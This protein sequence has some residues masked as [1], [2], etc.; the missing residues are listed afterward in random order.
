MS[1]LSAYNKKMISLLSELAVS[2]GERVGLAIFAIFLLSGV[3][4]SSF[5]EGSSEDRSATTSQPSVKVGDAVFTLDLSDKELRADLADQ[6]V[7]VVDDESSGTPCIKIESSAVKNGI[8]PGK[9]VTLPLDIKRFQGTK[10]LLS[11]QVRADNI[12]SAKENTPIFRWHGVKCQFIYNSPSRGMQSWEEGRLQSAFPWRHVEAICG[13]TRD[14]KDGRLR[15]GIE[16]ALGTVWIKDLTLTVLQT[17]AARPTPKVPN[18]PASTTLRGF[19]SPAHFKEQD[20][21]DLGKLNVNL[22]RW[23]LVGSPKELANYDAWLASKLDELGEALDAAFANGIKLVI[24]LHS[25]PG[26]RLT[27]DATLRMVMEKPYQDRF[28]NIWEDIARRFKGH[29]ALYA[30]D[31][32]NEPVQNHVSPPGLEDWLGIQ[33]KA[34]KAI[35]TIDATTPI[36]IEMDRWCQPDQ[37]IWLKGPVD[38]TNVIYQVH[39]YWPG[40]YTNQGVFTDQGIAKD[41]DVKTFGIPYPGAIKDQKIDKEAISQHLQPVR[42]FQLAY[43]VPIYVGEVGVVRWAPG[44]AQYLDDCISIFEEYGWDWTFH[45]F[46]EWGGWSAEAADLPYSRESHP[47]A[48]EPTDRLRVLTK[49]FSKNTP[50][51]KPSSNN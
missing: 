44:A 12:R 33:V 30:Y 8:A 11:A 46:R 2:F 38:V 49:W 41:Q 20:F 26:G 40:D 34:A 35:R 19:M 42:D 50:F 29:P 22:V 5:A 21:I 51:P 31:L 15:L 13:V 6:G 28:V 47:A 39:M 36:I 18:Q 10:L 9:M 45:A 23:Q 25:L 27:P 1:A 24:D 7:S 17:Q 3:A 48:A 16:G 37:Y 43:N 32:V 4:Q 14:A